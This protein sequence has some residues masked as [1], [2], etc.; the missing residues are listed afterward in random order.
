MMLPGIVQAQNSFGGTV[1]QIFSITDTSNNSPTGALGTF[2]TL[3]IGSTSAFNQP[4]PLAFRIR[5]NYAYTITAIFSGLTNIADGTTAGASNTLQP[6]QTGDIGFG[7]TAAID[8]SGAS[9]SG[10]GVGGLRSDTIATGYD[11]HAGWPSLTSADGHTPS[12]SKTLHNIVSSQ[13]ILNGDRIS[14]S[15]DNT[16]DDNFLLITLGVATLP[17]YFTPVTFSGTVTLTIAAT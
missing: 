2:S 14:A 9:V 6:I 4:T 17:Q 7:F 11:V 8:K 1:P 15:G 10:G 5:S 16:S 3:T 12:F 13:T